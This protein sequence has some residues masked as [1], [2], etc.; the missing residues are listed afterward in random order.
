MYDNLEQLFYRGDLD[1]CIIEGEQ[2]LLSYPEDE[3]VLFLMAVA[4]HDIVYD[5]G[6]EAV[7][8]AIRDY[9]IPYLRRILQLN[10]SNQKA[11]YNILDYPL[12]NEYALMQ[13]ARSKKHITQENKEEFIGYAERMLEDPDYV[14]YGY[15]FL[16]KIYE[17][18]EENQALLNSLEAGIYYSK[19]AN[20]GNREIRDKN[21][22]LYWIKKIYLLDRTKMV[23][24]EELTVLIDKEHT[25]FVSRNEYDFINLSDIAF[26]NNAPDLSLKMMMKAIKGENSALH[27]HEKLVEW[28]QRFAELIQNGYHNP[29]VFYYQLIIER[30]YNDLLNVSTDFYYHHA[31]EVINSHPELFSGYHFAGTFLYENERYA[32]AIP[33]LEKAVQLSSNAT[34][35]RRIADSEYLLNGMILSEIPVFSDYPA[36]IYNE[37]VLL[38]ECIDALEDES[39]KL[40]WHKMGRIVYEQAHEAFRKYFEEDQFESDYYNDLHT[41][42]MCCNNLA[43]K[44]LVLEDYQAAAEI[45]SEGLKYS[46]FMELHLVL[47]DALLDGGN[48]EQ[49]EEALNNY[50]SLYGRSDDY[51]S[52]TLYYR[53]RQIQLYEVMGS[54]DVQ[55][56][57]EEILTCIYQYII[58]N[59]ELED[60]NYR[61]L[62]AGKNILE[63]ILFQ[64]LDNQDLNIRKS[65]YEQAAERFP[66]EANPQFALMQIYNEEGNYGGVALAA[67]RYLENKKEFLL[68]AFDRAKTIYMIVKSDFLQGNYQE[69]ASVFS[70]YDADCE[71]AMDPEEYVLWVS[72]GVRV[73]EK[74]NNK[75]QTLAFAERFTTIYNTEEWGY[76]DLVESVELAK[77][78]VLYQAGNIKEAHA[79]LDQVRSVADY[80]SVAD[81]Y[82]ASWKKPG[83][84]SKFGF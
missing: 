36:D 47:I 66:G 72:Y 65:Y 4:Y 39:D 45:A 35:W 28:H 23:S 2:Y 61:D 54:S 19:K 15:D 81:E 59:P 79:I 82:K 63:G 68:D 50:F 84:F 17:S 5:E 55:R 73:Y 58:E 57:A 46:E 67:K 32:E 24:G 12:G 78:V 56:E 51:C 8:D 7:Y 3:E 34:A 27:I 22:S 70:Q 42:A 9:V 60:D 33:L 76:D 31:L 37:G 18:L 29:D 74:L 14:G 13:I 43:I 6:H 25:A 40:K 49:A 26:E 48:Y 64:H 71:A 75:D 62:E 10:P 38:N 80:D 44:H 77:A 41:R 16:V 20:A 53:A 30:N 11:L 21:T 69:A 52:K 83:L 1:Q